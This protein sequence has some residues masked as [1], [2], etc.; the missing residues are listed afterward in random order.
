MRS[1]NQRR[2]CRQV[3]RFN[4]CTMA[5]LK[6]NRPEHSVRWNLFAARTNLHSFALMSEWRHSLLMEVS[7]ERISAN[8]V[9]A[10]AE[11]FENHTCHPWRF[12]NLNWLINVTYSWI[13]EE[14]W[15]FR[16]SWILGESWTIWDCL[17]IDESLEIRLGI[18]ITH[19]WRFIWMNLNKRFMKPNTSIVLS[20]FSCCLLLKLFDFIL[21]SRDSHTSVVE[22][23]F[24]LALTRQA[25]N[26]FFLG[27]QCVFV[28]QYVEW[29]SK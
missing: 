2:A 9:H 7:V 16:D 5:S 15:I 8:G 10:L 3:V 21:S 14:S 1:L 22:I 19:H 11:Y 12:M 18:R 17:E 26:L 27:L 6:F 4:H 28:L 23:L 29:S 13:F 25:T 20:H 24:S